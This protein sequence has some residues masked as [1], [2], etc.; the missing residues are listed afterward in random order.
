MSGGRASG[1]LVSGGLVSPYRTADAEVVVVALGSIL[2][3]I[4]DVVDA[5]RADGHRIGALGITSFRPFPA[6]AVRRAVGDAA[7]V[8]VVEKAFSVGFG[9]VLATDVAMAVADAPARVS[10]VV[11]GLGGRPVP[12]A[13]LAAMLDD[14]LHGR[15]EPLRFLDLD[16]RVVARE[17]ARMSERRRSGP[18]AE[19]ILRDVG[20]AAGRPSAAGRGARP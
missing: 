7:Q 17:L 6:D 16:E 9:G 19:N 15:L 8:V 11:A 1:G 12:E 2:G 5:L 14:A 4:E 13:S 20:I 10:T 3:T 18:H